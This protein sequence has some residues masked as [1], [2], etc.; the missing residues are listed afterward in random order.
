LALVAKQF[1]TAKRLKL[2]YANFIFAFYIVL[3]AVMFF[4]FVGKA[5]D[6]KYVNITG[7]SNASDLNYGI[8]GQSNVG[9]GLTSGHGGIAF[10]TGDGGH[11]NPIETMRIWRGR[12]GIGTTNPSAKLHVIGTSLGSAWNTSSDQRFKMNIKPMNSALANVMLLKPVTYNW[13][14]TAFPNRGFNN[15]NQLGFIAQDVQKIFPE[16]VTT[17]ADGYLSMDYAKVT[18]ILVKAVQEQQ[19]LINE[20]KEQNKLLQEQI[21]LIKLQNIEMKASIENLQNSKTTTVST[22]R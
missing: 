5:Q 19:E 4:G 18:P 8:F 17:D 9:L 6:Q 11:T 1:R 14:V 2:E 7:N 21:T 22:N 10:W 3:V 16:L 12:V 20:I 13:N 15:L